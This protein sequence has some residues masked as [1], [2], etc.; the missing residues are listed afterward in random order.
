MGGLSRRLWVFIAFGMLLPVCGCSTPQVGACVYPDLGL[1]LIDR[2]VNDCGVLKLPASSR[3]RKA[4]QSCAQKALA[5][6]APVRFGS[7]WIGSDAASCFRVIR[8]VKSQL[9]AI[10]VSYDVLIELGQK[11]FVGRCATVAFPDAKT[12]PWRYFEVSNCTAD[13]SGFDLV[14]ASMRDSE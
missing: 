10:D 5:S 3:R 8:D 9:W 4:A 1:A 7:G 11:L 6:H 12:S 14:V 2:A 13:K